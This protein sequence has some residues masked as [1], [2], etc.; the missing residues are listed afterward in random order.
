[1]TGFIDLENMNTFVGY[2]VTG[3][4]LIADHYDAYI[5]DLWGVI[6][7]GH[8]IYDAAKD[9]LKNLMH[10]GKTVHL[11]TN[12]PRSSYGI[13]RM[14]ASLGLT[15]DYYSNIISAGQKTLDLLN[16]GILMP[17][18]KHPLNAY[19]ID[20]IGLCDWLDVA[21]LKV[22]PDI[23]TADLI[24]SIHMDET[25]HTPTPFVP[26]FESAIALG[27][28]HICSNPD[29][30]VVKND[31][32]LARVGSLADLYRSLGGTVFEIGKPHP[33]MF[34][35]IMNLHNA[36]SILLIGDSLVTD[37]TAASYIGVDS[38][39]VTSGYHQDEFRSAS[40]LNNKR[41]FKNYGV[42]PTYVCE[43][44]SWE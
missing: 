9:V 15:S 34:E 29:K 41:L 4:E 13:A 24:L 21:N 3:L 22:I 7:N 33:V 17:G 14:L 26:L 35:N 2:E 28:P 30:Y 10:Q 1:M 8:H 32:K 44:L 23:H 36:K 11:I 42:S 31:I 37:I 20:D 40:R 25:L 38:L 6:Y 16:S 12:N 18:R 5:I 27:I 19:I 43:Y 39:L